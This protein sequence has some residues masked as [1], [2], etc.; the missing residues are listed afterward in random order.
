MVEYCLHIFHKLRSYQSEIN[1]HTSPSPQV[2][3]VSYCPLC[4]PRRVHRLPTG[5]RT[6]LTE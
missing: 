2:C 3:L 5:V 1:A 4:C 6:K